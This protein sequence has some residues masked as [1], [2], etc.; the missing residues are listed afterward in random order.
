MA[1]LELSERSDFDPWEFCFA[2]KEF[3]GEPTI[4]SEQ[5]DAQEF[6]NLAFERLETALKGTS[7]KYLLQSVFGGKT[8]GQLICK[9]CGKVKNRIES[10]YNLSLQVKDRKSAYESLQ[11]M[12][13][14]EDIGDYECGACKK[15]GYVKKRMLIAETPNVLILHLQRI[16][17]N[18][19]TF[20]QDK[21]NS[22]FDFPQVL[23]LEPYSYHH[24]MG[25][26]R[27]EA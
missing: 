5:K 27:A 22:F 18:F 19:D 10:F 14:E 24:V 13:S 2:M 3:G 7:R 1:N 11:G 8:C 6:L 9:N 26:E 23:D 12:I 15:R 4:T 20:Q 25:K 21:L 17:F 16:V